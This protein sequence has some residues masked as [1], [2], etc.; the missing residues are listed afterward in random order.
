MGNYLDF[1]N[2]GIGLTASSLHI[3]QWHACAILDT[4]DM[5]CWGRSDEGNYDKK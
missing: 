2:L 3:G 5:K 1:V 4:D